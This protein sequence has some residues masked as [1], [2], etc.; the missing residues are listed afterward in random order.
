MDSR[1]AR[2]TTESQPP[3]IG[4]GRFD[5]RFVELFGLAYRVAYRIVG[6]TEEAKD[7]AQEALARAQQRWHRVGDAPEGWV[8]RVSANQAIGTWRKRQHRSVPIDVAVSGSGD[9]QLAERLDLVK[10][11]GH[12]SRRQREVVILRYLADRPEEEVARVLGCSVG[13]V[14]THASRGLAALRAELGGR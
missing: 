3:T 14:K 4:P 2:L 9:G 10:A 6:T 13:A 11:L 5:D 1:A 12:L 8:A 7:A